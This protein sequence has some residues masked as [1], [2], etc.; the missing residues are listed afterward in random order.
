MMLAFPGVGPVIQAFV[1]MTMNLTTFTAGVLLAHGENGTQNAPK[2]QTVLRQPSLFA[3]ALALI[4]K[5]LGL[6]QHWH[7]WLRSGSPSPSL[8]M[9]L[10]RLPF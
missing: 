8:R 3:I 6:L 5:A 2:W 7:R 10:S 9:V 1:L 4:L